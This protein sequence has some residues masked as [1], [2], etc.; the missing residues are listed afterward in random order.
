MSFSGG[1][2][3]Q[4][5]TCTNGLYKCSDD[6]TQRTQCQNG[7][8]INVQRCDYG[9]DSSIRNGVPI[10]MCKSQPTS[11]PTTPTPALRCYPGTLRC[12]VLN[13]INSIQ[14]CNSAGTGYNLVQ[15]CSQGKVC[16]SSGSFPTCVDPIGTPIDTECTG[17]AV[18]CENTERYQCVGGEW[19]RNQ[20]PGECATIIRIPTPTP[21]TNSTSRA[22]PTPTIRLSS[23]PSTVLAVCNGEC[24]PLADESA[25]GVLGNS[26]QNISCRNTNSAS[27]C[28][29][30][31][32]LVQLNNDCP[33]RNGIAYCRQNNPKWANTAFPAGCITHDAAGNPIDNVDKDKLSLAAC[34][35]TSVSSILCTYVDKKYCDVEYTTYNVMDYKFS[36]CFGTGYQAH[37]NVLNNPEYNQ[38]EFTTTL[39]SSSPATID[40][41]I[42]AAL[43][44]G[45][46]MVGGVFRK[47]GNEGGFYHW[48]MITGVDPATG[49]WLFN[50][51]YFNSDNSREDYQIESPIL[52]NYLDIQLE[53]VIAIDPNE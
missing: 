36:S 6:G 28:C 22:T 3:C 32:N 39:V 52:Q 44:N 18:K 38:G 16:G 50:D 17:T 47:I 15:T 23:T 35:Q 11:V 24:W 7:Q 30:D 19:I 48:T 25:C 42:R 53:T 14:V 12:T 8:W 20:N 9:C 5:A 41:K 40:D 27:F 2:Y 26:A 51:P 29:L 31:P 1:K 45:P 21:I 13:T 46:V 37:M 34:G 49:K 43:E 10:N 4:T 33:I